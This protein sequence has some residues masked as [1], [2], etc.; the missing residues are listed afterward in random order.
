MERV[1]IYHPN[2]LQRNK[3]NIRF[4]YPNNSSVFIYEVEDLLPVLDKVVRLEQREMVEMV[5]VSC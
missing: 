4:S 5:V 1:Y 3:Q 2:K